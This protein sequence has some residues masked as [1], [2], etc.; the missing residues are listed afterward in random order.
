MKLNK[1]LSSALVLVM[2][3]ASICTV[4]PVTSRAAEA[5]EVKVNVLSADKV[6]TDVDTVKEICT[7][8]YGRYGSKY[9]GLYFE[10][11]QEML[12]YEIGRGY[13]DSVE[14]A[15]YSLF[16]NRYTGFV[17]YKNNLTG[18]ILTSNPIDPAY[19][20]R[21]SNKPVTLSNDV[22]SQLE[23]K[24]FQITDYKVK[25]KV[26]SSYEWI[27]QGNLLKVSALD[28]GIRV[29]YALGQDPK[30]LAAPRAMLEETF[31]SD[32]AEPAFDRLAAM[33]EE[34]IGEEFSKDFAE[35]SGL[36]YKHGVTS[37]IL[38]IS[39]YDVGEMEG[40]YNEYG[41][42]HTYSVSDALSALDKY[43][44]AKLGETN[45]KYEDISAL[46]SSIKS[47]FAEYSMLVPEELKE[48]GTYNNMVDKIPALGKGKNV[49]YIEK[50]S[51]LSSLSI[52]SGAI[53]NAVPGYS[54]S[55]VS[56]DEQEC[57]F[58]EPSIAIARF[59]VS[60]DY[61]L[62]EDG[63][64]V[65]EIPES[66]MKFDDTLFA[67]QGITPLKYFG[68]GDM[69]E[70]GYI[71][72][73]DGSG[74]VTEFDDF[75]FGE[76]SDRSNVNMYISSKIYGNDYSYSKITGAHREQITLPVF[77]IVN[78]VVA[79]DGTVEN[80]YA[81]SGDKVT[82][83]FLAI[84]E[85]GSSLTSLTFAS[86]PASHKYASVYATTDFYPF[87][88]INLSQSLSVSSINTYLMVAQG[89][90][91][92]SFK[93]RYVMLTDDSV[94]E[95]AGMTSYYPSS[96]VGM[97]HYY[98]DYLEKNGVLSDL[99]DTAEDLPLYIEALGSMDI[100]KRILSFPVTVSVPL[101]TF[102]DVERMYN[103][104]SNAVN[105]LKD[106]AKEAQEEADK[107][108][109]NKDKAEQMKR[110]Q[111]MAD[112]YTELAENVQNIKNINF[113]LT[114]FTNG[115]M[116]S[117]YPAKVKW[118]SS[119][120]G[121]KGFSS[122]V[123]K[124]D[125]INALNDGVSNFSVYP[126]FDFMYINET[127]AFDGVSKNKNAAKMVDN[128]YASKQVY[129]SIAQEYE[130]LPIYLVSSDT[131]SGLYTKFNKE[132]SEFK[133]ENISVSTMGSD[134][135]SNLGDKKVIARETAMG[136][137]SRVLDRMD[138]DGY[139]IMGDAGNV[140]SLKYMDHLLNVSIDSSHF[141]YSSYAVPFMGMV[142][143]GSVNYAGSPLNYSGSPD[144]DILRAIE[145]GASAY[146]ILC[147]QNTNHL[148]NDEEL[149]KYY[150]VDYENWFDKIVEQYAK[151]NGAIGGLQEY[152]IVDHKV[153]IAERVVDDEEMVSNYDDL[154]TEFIEDG[155]RKGISRVIDVKIKEM[156]ANDRSGGIKLV[157]DKDSLV[158]ALGDVLDI[159]IDADTIENN[160]TVKAYV[161]AID[162]VIADFH[163]DYNVDGGEVVNFS[164]DDVKYESRYAYTTDS[165]ATDGDAY[166]K[167][168]FSN[169]NG[170]VVMVTYR[171]AEGK[172]VQFILNYNNFAVNVRLE[173]GKASI[174]LEAYGYARIDK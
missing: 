54:L 93:M 120:G 33:L 114:G 154:A 19:Q 171:S 99:T 58:N 74:S 116:S 73:P 50:Y 55:Q 18:Q 40:I 146:Y 137:V 118:E 78:D 61:T 167:T 104:L 130:T 155:V 135:N 8:E 102:E 90:Y 4:I 52:V 109:D 60:L 36:T 139:S 23:I 64:L 172:E 5:D 128:R 174:P 72:Y 165:V 1:I 49:V 37:K 159:T 138:K 136:H 144:Y 142:L 9:H 86:Y 31:V 164:A 113:R 45:E 145:N 158:S 81:S 44:K 76:G 57:G 162:T 110:Y 68:S 80:G 107:L 77:G 119:V 69:N 63:S 87:D 32:I 152:N 43:A 88:E 157:V 143:H 84:I 46:I 94:A 67:I 6:I 41:V 25:D 62:A 29:R 106:K 13:I 59:E 101:T 149:S 85:E 28:N 15:K 71:F 14:T 166:V 170:N 112:K 7:N 148:K 89:K 38:Y 20:T 75:F 127:S 111:A 21:N 168:K 42:Y 125:K 115:G 108:K 48:M 47:I 65:V 117:T 173:A 96:Y 2:L 79:S 134:L 17:Y 160:A 103:E 11:A 147:T 26:Y 92:G 105:I 97:A 124:A 163:K 53:K 132:Y 91:K 123:N 126:D 34:S 131:I 30:D 100:L 161:D 51:T 27:T 150:G 141:R 35:A 56:I 153:L 12:D 133:N 129:N 151:L 22:L 16:V 70:D 83:G 82:N 156:R 3:F 121:K 140:Y 169:D 66:E 24:Y 98:R 95:N 122:L 10:N 39:S